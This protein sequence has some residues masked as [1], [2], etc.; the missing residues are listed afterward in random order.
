[1]NVPMG[2]TLVGLNETSKS[3]WNNYRYDGPYSNSSITNKSQVLTTAQQWLNAPYLW[4]GKTFMGVDCSGFV[5]TVFKVHGIKLLRD[6]YQQAE[7]GNLVDD[8]QL[9]KEGDIAF[10]QNE[11]GRV[12]HVGI[13]MSP[14]RIIHAAGKVRIDKID[15]EGIITE[16][17]K[18]T[19][20]LHSVRRMG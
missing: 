14:G 6:A 17:E 15:N 5:Q 18:R 13:L 3:L 7:Q 10:F 4:G 1:M 11:N 9:A 12:T 16:T 8:L 2:S 19:H 20:K